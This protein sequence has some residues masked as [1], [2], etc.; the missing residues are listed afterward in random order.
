MATWSSKRRIIYGGSILGI[1]LL[2]AIV[3]VF[4]FFYKAPT[5]S[6]GIRNGDEQSVDCGGSCINLCQSAFLPPK[7]KWGGGK[8]E[9][10]ADDLYNVAS[11]IINPNTN[12]AAINVPYKFTL[13]DAQG[14]LITEKKGI[15]TLPAHRNALAFEPSINVGKRDVSKVTF[16]FIA[17]PSWFKS[18]DSLNGLAVMD[19]RYSED[20]NGSSLEVTLENRNLLPYGNIMVSV[21]LY[22][23]R[24]NAIGF[25]RTRIDKIISRG[26]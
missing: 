26:I 13:Y 1:F 9:K 2:I 12:G 20:E 11:Y 25:S 17:S 19:K 16:E 18:H 14:I 6:D 3:V 21:V 10:I 8:Y 24:D 23:D 5:C 15:V 4:S 7:I 22:D